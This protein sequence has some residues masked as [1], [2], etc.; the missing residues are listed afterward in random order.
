MIFVC[1]IFDILLCGQIFVFSFTTSSY[2]LNL[3]ILFKTFE[4]S[5]YDMMYGKFNGHI[6]FALV[7]QTVLAH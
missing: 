3:I 1:L 4:I 7:S 6:G 2:V 5:A